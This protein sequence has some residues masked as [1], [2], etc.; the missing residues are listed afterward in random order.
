MAVKI[1]PVT[2]L[3]QNITTVLKALEESGQPLYIT[4]YGRPKAVLLSY[5]EY[6]ALIRELEDLEDS[7]CIYEGKDE[8]TKSLEEVLAEEA[9]A[10]RVHGKT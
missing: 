1:M 3:R 6:E 10:A 5:R 2:D 8:P 4:Q 7:L 9:A